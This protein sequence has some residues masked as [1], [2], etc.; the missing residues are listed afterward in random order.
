[1]QA[2]ELVNG[3]TLTHWLLRGARKM[4]GELPPEPVSLYDKPVSG[5]AAPPPDFDVDISQAVRL[6]L[7]VQDTGSYSP[8]KVEAAWAHAEL[9][10]PNGIIPLSSLKPLDE[11]G[12]RCAAG[13]VELNGYTGD[14]VRVKT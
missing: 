4:L 5:R 13:P 9:D 12:L 2:L 10:G 1:L 6:W 14:G 8:E 7:L 11:S 3:E